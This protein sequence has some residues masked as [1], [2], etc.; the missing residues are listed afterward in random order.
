MC[1][2]VNAS[3]LGVPCVLWSAESA[4]RSTQ[5]TCQT[6]RVGAQLRMYVLTT[7]TPDEILNLVHVRSYVRH[8]VA[9]NRKASQKGWQ[10]TGLSK[11]FGG[12]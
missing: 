3:G 2:Q 10:A 1:L 9:A 4:A 12:F 6:T 5:I 11:C 7:S 8:I